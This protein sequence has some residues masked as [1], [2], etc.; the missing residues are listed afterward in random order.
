MKPSRLKE[1]LEGYPVEN[2]PVA[3]FAIYKN[4]KT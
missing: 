1:N 4:K 3:S 2:L